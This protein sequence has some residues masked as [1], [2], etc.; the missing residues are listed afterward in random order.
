M[1]GIRKPRAL[2]ASRSTTSMATTEAIQ[3]GRNSRARLLAT[4]TGRYSGYAEDAPRP[5]CDDARLGFQIADPSERMPMAPSPA[6]LVRSLYAPPLPLTKSV[7]APADLSLP[8]AVDV[9][10]SSPEMEATPVRWVCRGCGTKDQSKLVPGSDGFD[11]CDDCGTTDRQQTVSLDRQGNCAREDDNTDVADH[12]T[13]DAEKE[14]AMAA[15][16]GDENAEE[17]RQ[18]LLAGAGGTRVKKSVSRRMDLGGVQGKLETIVKNETAERIEGSRAQVQKFQRIAGY[19]EANFDW[20]G[21]SMN[22]SLKPHLRIEARRAVNNAFL[23]AGVCQDRGCCLNIGKRS[24]ST[25]ALGLMQ[26]C[27]ERLLTVARAPAATATA[28]A[29]GDDTRRAEH[30]ELLRLAREVT[31]QLLGKLLDG[32]RQ[33][34]DQNQSLGQQDQVSSTMGLLVDWP[35][36][37]IC[38]PC[39]SAAHAASASVAG[40]GHGET[41]S[42]IATTNTTNTTNTTINTTNQPPP[43]N[44]HHNHQALM[45][46][47]P[48]QLPPSAVAGGTHMAMPPLVQ[49][50]SFPSS[51]SPTPSSTSTNDSPTDVLW[52]VRDTLT[53]AARK[54]NVRA[55]VRHAALHALGQPDVADWIR[56]ANVLPVDVLSVVL[57]D[58]V[59]VALK[60]DDASSELM[61]QVC[62]ENEI[63]PTTARNATATLSGLISIEP[64]TSVGV[65][66]EQIF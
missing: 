17:R 59:S 47:P 45:L 43:F 12:R 38:V 51:D 60:V 28:A 57:L 61:A 46:P 44:H 66:G 1:P 64:A 25:L 36:E 33:L 56:S 2:S 16:R 27:F 34:H 20:M 54:A 50:P 18:R 40:S 29:E 53:G 49:N 39:G 32:V 4:V 7:S 21:K 26:H 37:K 35:L 6:T 24:N 3:N 15:A 14:S 8:E 30:A 31:P 11:V 22:E 23:H 65:F 52:T 58:A 48:L 10:M 13:R 41:N 19:L 9:E 55:D 63:S 5:F 42:T 62:Y